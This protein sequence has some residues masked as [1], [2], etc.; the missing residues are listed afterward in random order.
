MTP[1]ISAGNLMLLSRLNGTQTTAYLLNLDL[2]KSNIAESPDWPILLS[3]LVEQ[4]RDNLPGLRRWNYRMNEDV[5]FRLFEGVESDTAAER[6][7]KLEHNGSSKKLARTPIVELPQLVEA[8]IYTLRDGENEFAQF[9][10][11][12]FDLEESTLKNLRP[13]HREPP[14]AA[15]PG[16]Y[17]L[18]T[19][20]TL[21]LMLGIVLIIGLA[22]GD[23]FVLKAKRAVV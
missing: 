11:N 6:E 5:T 4:R 21:L 12:F 3:N 10:V 1:I 14:I 22:F 23:W 19:T 7:L 15:A 18:D 9:A 16:G 8:G 20:L 17:E 13:G 2:S